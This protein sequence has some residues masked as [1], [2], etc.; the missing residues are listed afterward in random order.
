[1]DF[2]LPDGGMIELSCGGFF[3][4]NRASSCLISDNSQ[5]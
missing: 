5:L 3:D 2:M 4:L 1:M